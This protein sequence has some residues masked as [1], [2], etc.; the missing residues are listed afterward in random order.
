MTAGDQ[1]VGPIGGWARK[2][3]KQMIVV[4]G[5][6]AP[7]ILFVTVFLCANGYWWGL[8]FLPFLALDLWLLRSLVRYARTQRRA[9]RSAR[10]R[11]AS[12]S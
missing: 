3:Y 10:S 1:R 12:D 8:V 2:H 9:E 4:R 6:L 5:L 11:R 7:W